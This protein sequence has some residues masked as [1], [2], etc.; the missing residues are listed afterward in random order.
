[1]RY[2]VFY[3]REERVNQGNGTPE[4]KR[5]RGR[6]KLFVLPVLIRRKEGK[7]E[8]RK[9]GTGYRFGSR[10]QRGRKKEV[11]RELTEKRGREGRGECGR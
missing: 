9:G 1:M 6:K 11:K 5:G 7:R 10:L 2:S 4:I 3:A 8:T